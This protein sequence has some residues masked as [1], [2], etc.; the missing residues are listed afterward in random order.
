MGKDRR[1]GT[2]LIF[3]RGLDL[4][5]EG[6]EMTE[7]KTNR[8]D[9]DSRVSKIEELVRTRKDDGPE[10]ANNPSTEC[11]HRHCGIVSVGHRGSDF[12]VRGFI[13]GSDGGRVK[14]GVVGEGL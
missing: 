7:L 6:T 4:A 3:N 14:V 1:M 5:T 8:G 11:R 2:N 12:G 13:F 9:N 10:Q